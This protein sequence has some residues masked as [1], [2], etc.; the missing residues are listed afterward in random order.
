MTGLTAP[1]A[2]QDRISLSA[3]EAR[4]LA[5]A[6]LGRLGFDPKEAGIVADHLVD[7]ALCG[8]EYSGL[9][10]LLNLA[11]SERMR[12]PRR[13]IE[14]LHETPVSARLDGGNTNGMLAMVRATDIAIA[15]ASEHGFGIVGIN[16]IWM[17]G[18]SAYYVERIARAGLIGVHTVSSRA[19]VAPP[20]AASA[21]IGTNPIA[22]GF[23]S[24]TEPLVIDL[25]TSAFMFTDLM[26]RE[27]RGE[28]LPESVAIDAEGRPTLD[29]ALARMGAVLSFG[30]YKGFALGLAMTA[31]GVAAGSGDDPERSG[32]LV[33]AIKPDLLVPIDEY[34]RE[35]TAMVE[36][37][38]AT[39]RQPGVNEIRVPS[40][41]AF[42]E[43][44]QRMREGIVIDRVVYDALRV[45]QAP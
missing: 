11:E 6:A 25:G 32:Y 36:R 9:P 4:A 2:S 45:L 15:K 44:T 12:E 22:F 38:K 34:R 10:K 26:F 27:R 31:L 8:Y 37:I 1:G 21:A 24:E 18:R 35:L 19:Q 20:G 7:A 23:P 17:S 41:R 30:G 5:Q 39:P 3:D 14:T 16:N 33:M 13:S 42:R 29:P 43:R 28:S 40:E